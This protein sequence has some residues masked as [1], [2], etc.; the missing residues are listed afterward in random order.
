MH[1]GIES[2]SGIV[3]HGLNGPELP[4]QPQP[5]VSQCRLIEKESD[6]QQ[7]PKGLSADPFCWVFREDSFDSVTRIRRGRVYQTYGNSQPQ[8]VAVSRNPSPDTLGSTPYPTTH[9]N[10]SMFRYVACTSLLNTPHKGF[11]MTFIVGSGVG[12]ARYTIVQIESLISGDVMVTLK[13]QSPL[14]VIPDLNDAEVPEASRKP[15]RQA[16]ERAVNSAFRETAVSVVDQCRN[17]MATVLSHFLAAEDPAS[18]ASMLKAE[19][20]PLG[21]MLTQRKREVCG[22]AALIVARM[23]SRGKSNEQIT[24]G[25]KEPSEEDA[26]FAVHALGLVMREIGWAR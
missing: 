20:A 8:A 6:W 18:A 1:L 26:Q 11:G 14:G 7:L 3:F 15:V 22:S 25:L 19:L 16:L 2:Q 9:R 12:T 21:T 10:L 5:N 23:H 24:K 4:L 17:A 13:E